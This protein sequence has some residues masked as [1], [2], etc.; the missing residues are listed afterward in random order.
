MKG[1]KPYYN[2]CEAMCLINHVLQ[3]LRKQDGGSQY[4]RPLQQALDDLFDARA[5]MKKPKEKS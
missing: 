3:D 2:V 1:L 4:T 5:Q